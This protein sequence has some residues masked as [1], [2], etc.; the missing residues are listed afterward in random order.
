MSSLLVA[1]DD[2]PSASH[3]LRD[4]VAMARRLGAKVRL[5]R[6]VGVPADF[7]PTEWAASPT[8]VVDGLLATARR[9]LEELAILVPDDLLESLTVQVGT[10][11]DAICQSA[12]EHDC[13]MIVIGAPG[14]GFFDRLVGTTAAK[15]VNHADRAVYVVPRRPKDKA[16]AA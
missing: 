11:W 4:G 10:A 14:H 5:L 13:D 9:D 7:A 8:Q 1:V 15:I 6:V 3:V 12:N 2:S 16:A